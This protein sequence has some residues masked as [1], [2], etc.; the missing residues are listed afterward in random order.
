MTD[1]VRSGLLRW[2]ACAALAL[3]IAAAA[4]HGQQRAE[5]ILYVTASAGYRHDVLDLSQDV[6]KEIGARSGRFTVTPTEDLS[7]F[8]PEKLQVFA[9]LVFF[10]SGELPMTDGQ[11]RA[12]LDFVRSGKGFVGI[13]SAA[14]T[15]Y[16]WPAYLAL[17]GGYFN[18][19]PWHQKVMIDV[20]DHPNPVV[21]F[22]GPSFR[23]ADEIYQISDFDYRHSHVLLRL[24]PSSV[25]LTLGTVRPRFYGWPLAWTQ[26]YGKGRVFYTA[27]GHE[28]AV[29]LDPRYQQL[30]L[31]AVLWVTRRNANPLGQ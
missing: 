28:P 12:L 3:T 13:H 2:L 4:A 18:D 15:F 6:L 7:T 11:K 20:A 17:I 25:D 8:T 23:I 26:S 19:H 5:R 22:L 24:R 27:L 10:T 14:D 1:R 21:A 16:Q 9:A 30:L 31:N 29:W